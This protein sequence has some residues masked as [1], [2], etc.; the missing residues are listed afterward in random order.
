M[1]ISRNILLT[2][3]ESD[4]KE[5]TKKLLKNDKEFIKKRGK[6][7]NRKLA[8]LNKQFVWLSQTVSWC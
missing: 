3:R 1:S 2:I 4:Q 7:M 6:I 5:T 8:K